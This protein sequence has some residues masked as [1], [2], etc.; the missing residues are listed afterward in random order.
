M[1][2]CQLGRIADGFGRNGLHTVDEG[3]FTGTGRQ[4]DLKAQLGKEGKPE[5][6][7]L[8]HVEGPGDPDLSHGSLFLFQ[9]FI[10]KDPLLFIVIDIQVFLGIAD[11]QSR[12]SFAAVA[13]D[14]MIA[15]RK[16]IDRQKTVVSALAAAALSGMVGEFFQFLRL[17]DLAASLAPDALFADDSASVSAHDACNIRPDDLASGDLLKGHQDSII[18]EGASLYNDLLAHFAVITDLDDLLQRVADDRIRQSC[19]DIADRSAFLLSLFDA[20]V[21]E[22]RAAAA[23]IDRL[24]G[25]NGRFGKVPDR[26]VQR[27]GKVLQEGPAAR[28]A[29][30]VQQDIMD[31]AVLDADAFHVLAAYIQNKLDAGQEMFRRLIVGHSLDLAQI[32]MKGRLNQ[33]FAVTGGNSCSNICLFGDLGINVF[34]DLFGLVDG[35]AFIGAVEGIQKAVVFIHQ[36]CFCRGRAGIDTQVNRSLGFGQIG[37]LHLVFAMAFTEGPVIGFV[38][39]Q[40]LQ[41]LDLAGDHPVHVSGSLINRIKVQDRTLFRCVGCPDR[42]KKLRIFG[43]DDFVGGQFQG[44]DKAPAQ[45][46]QEIQ[47]AAQKS[48]MAADRFALSQSGNGLIDNSLKNGSGYILFGSSLVDHG[49]NVGLGKNTAAGRYGVNG[50]GLFRQLVESARV[51][52]QKA[53][54][55]IDKCSRASGAGTVHTL[56][57]GGAEISDLS[58]LA[59]QFDGHIGQRSQLFNGRR[60]SNDLL[61]KGD[62]EPLGHGQAARSGDVDPYLLPLQAGIVCPADDT[63]DGF[64][65]IGKM[66]L[67]F[68]V[69]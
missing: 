63:G 6:I 21:H 31:H 62:G 22:Y 39:E 3:P 10:V 34:Q 5:R 15:G 32:G 11:L 49:L 50:R 26:H 17:H 66:S 4:D 45:L 29:G 69:N 64:F 24:F 12:P 44:F 27:M 47:R 43:N 54:H 19:A 18:V 35:T 40:R 23:K 42:Y 52:L 56:F 38:F 55:L 65:N 53:C 57:D 28:R 67:I 37:P 41:A 46:G 33:F 58:I 14:Q 7:I 8:V 16:I 30:F 2:V 51:G 1:A 13:R 25:R 61:H 68:T 9:R 59:S 20:A 60:G 36:D 48:H